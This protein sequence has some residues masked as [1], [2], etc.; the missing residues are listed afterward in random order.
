MKIPKVLLIAGLLSLSAAAS[1]AQVIVRV[2]PVAPRVVVTR[3]VA[4]SPR[5]VWVNEEWRPVRGRYVYSGGYWAAP[6]R[7]GARFIP[8]HWRATRRGSVWIPGHWM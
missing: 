8:G 2:R 5:H 6:P 7:A 1:Q 3:P 4:P